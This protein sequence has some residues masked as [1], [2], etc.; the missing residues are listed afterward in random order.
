M[1]RLRVPPA[2]RM[3]G[4][5]HRWMRFEPYR[6]Q[7]YLMY[8]GG[9]MAKRS[10]HRAYS[11]HATGHT[12]CPHMPLSPFPFAPCPFPL[13][14]LPFPLFTFPFPLCLRL[15]RSPHH[16]TALPIPP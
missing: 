4:M 9:H 7:A 11:L 15:T 2:G 8:A 14:S 3:K 13:S 5:R 12:S 1:I 10:P 16:L 6:P